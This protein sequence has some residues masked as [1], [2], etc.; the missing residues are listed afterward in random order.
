VCLSATFQKGTPFY[1]YRTNRELN[2]FDCND[3]LGVTE[4]AVNALPDIAH[5][6]V[7]TAS[8]AAAEL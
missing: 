2:P 5:R 6:L 1:L 4:F 3:G 7:V 8:G